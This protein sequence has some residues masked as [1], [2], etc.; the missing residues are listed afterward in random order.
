[1]GPERQL[2]N[3]NSRI[4]RYE[5]LLLVSRAIST[6]RNLND[7]FLTLKAELARV[8]Q[9]DGIAI[10]HYSPLGGIRW[11]LAEMR[12]KPIQNLPKSAA[13]DDLASWVFQN[14]Q[15]VLIRCTET[16]SR[17]PDSMARL[18][19][20]GVAS[21]CMLPLTTV[22]RRIGALSLGSAQPDTYGEEDLRFLSSVADQVAVAIDA[23][24]N[25]EE[26]AVNGCSFCSL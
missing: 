1:V 10:A 6:N 19:M 18:G 16:E 12:G 11:G 7:L 26:R 22:R 8:A 2:N 3:D 9:F 21:L 5:T 25:L 17:F 20:D 24:I 14:Q 4:A 13:E 23:A 15:P